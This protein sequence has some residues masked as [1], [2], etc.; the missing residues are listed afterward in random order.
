MVEK[1]GDYSPKNVCGLSSFNPYKTNK[2][3]HSLMMPSIDPS[4]RKNDLAKLFR[5]HKCSGYI[6]IARRARKYSLFKFPK[7]QIR[8]FNRITYDLGFQDL[9]HCKSQSSNFIF[10]TILQEIK[11][12][13][14]RFLLQDCCSSCVSCR[15]S[16][17][18]LVFVITP[19]VL[20]YF[21]SSTY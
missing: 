12:T 13:T 6:K 5:P 10:D 20:V 4:A 15:F 17:L 8:H 18:S 21:L 16:S 2:H 3:T 14:H 11:F 9:C 1:I 19:T 7:G